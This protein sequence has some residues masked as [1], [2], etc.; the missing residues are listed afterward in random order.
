MCLQPNRPSSPALI[1]GAAVDSD[2]LTLTAADGTKG[3]AASQTRET[4]IAMVFPDQSMPDLF[5]RQVIER[6][7]AIAPEV[8]IVVFKS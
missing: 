2:D 4:E 1:A 7:K 5:G 6:L 3:P 8:K